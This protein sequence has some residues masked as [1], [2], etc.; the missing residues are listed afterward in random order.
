MRN[1]N[2]S[3]LTKKVL[4]ARPGQDRRNNK[5]RVFGMCLC[6]ALTGFVSSNIVNSIQNDTIIN[7]STSHQSSQGIMNAGDLAAMI[8]TRG[9]DSD[10]MK[11]QTERSELPP[12]AP[13]KNGY[14]KLLLEHKDDLTIYKN[15]LDDN[16]FNVYCGSFRSAER[17][18]N[19]EATVKERSGLTTTKVVSNN[20]WYHVNVGNNMEERKAFNLI[21]QLKNLKIFSCVKQKIVKD[22]PPA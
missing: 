12:S 14:A 9:M 10:V 8:V 11:A 1:L 6:C 17:A 4:I 20:N 7:Y 15:D 5:G 18:S 19:L 21:N 16:N 2:K 22:Q 3:G 13:I